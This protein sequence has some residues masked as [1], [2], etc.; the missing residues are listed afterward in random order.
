VH[1]NN[2]F[3]NIQSMKKSI[4]MKKLFY[5]LTALFIIIAGCN[6]RPKEKESKVKVKKSIAVLPFRNDSTMDQLLSTITAN[7]KA[8]DNLDVE[9]IVGMFAENGTLLNDNSEML[10][11]KE[12]IKKSFETLQ[13]TQ[14]IE[15]KRDKVEVSLKGNMAYEIVNQT[16]S[17]QYQ[18]KEPQTELN[19]Y[20]HVWEKQKDGSWKVLIDMNNSRTSSGQ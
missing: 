3:E 16:V 19:K 1:N 7:D 8:W 18:G 6:Q 5:L 10:R 15:F 11:G 4:I 9:K 13:K 12:A 20:I 2:L 14:K 17:F